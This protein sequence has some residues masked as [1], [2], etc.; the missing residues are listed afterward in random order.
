[1][2]ASELP[3]RVKL[4]NIEGFAALLGLPAGHCLLSGN[5]SPKEYFRLVAPANDGLAISNGDVKQPVPVFNCWRLFQ[6]Y[7]RVKQSPHN[8]PLSFSKY[9][10]REGLWAIERERSI[11]ATETT[12]S[13]R[14][15]VVANPTQPAN[16]C[17]HPLDAA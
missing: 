17:W 12:L 9:A 4:V 15:M 3:N 13:F 10:E 2:S 7:R 14:Q 5:Q 8:S 16:D 11:N 1:M 6:E